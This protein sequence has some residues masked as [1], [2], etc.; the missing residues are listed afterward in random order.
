MFH[1][2]QQLVKIVKESKF[3]PLTKL[4]L[5]AS[6]N[7]LISKKTNIKLVPLQIKK[8]QKSI[9]SFLIP[10]VFSMNFSDAH[11]LNTLNLIRIG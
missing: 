8:A 9:Y 2:K 10:P 4:S 7:I 5:L 6:K 3:H 11:A 1:L